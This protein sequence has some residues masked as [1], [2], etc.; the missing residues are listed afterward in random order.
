MRFNVH[1]SHCSWTGYINAP[2]NY[3]ET[4]Y[5]GATATTVDLGSFA[6][7]EGCTLYAYEW[8]Y[9][10]P[11]THTEVTIS[12]SSGV[13]TL[14]VGLI[15]ETAEL[16]YQVQAKVGSLGYTS[17]FIYL[18]IQNEPV[19]NTAPSLEAAPENIEMWVGETKVLNLGTVIDDQGDSTEIVW[20]SFPSFASK[21][22]SY[23]LV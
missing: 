14:Q 6:Y 23:L 16:S 8:T 15:S 13:F 11:T 22:G 12:E 9:I 17:F 7:S 5:I 18:S 1:I 19:V 21:Q 20:D 10:I 2:K 4:L 3:A